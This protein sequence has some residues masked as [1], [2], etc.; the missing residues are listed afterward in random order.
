MPNNCISCV[1]GF[2][3]VDGVC[4]PKPTN[5][6]RNV[7]VIDGICQEYC[8]RECKTCNNTRGDCYECSHLYRRNKAGQC[9]IGSAALDFAARARFFVN[10]VRRGGFKFTFFVVDDLW[11]YSYHDKKY[12]GVVRQVLDVI[13]LV[14]EKQWELMGLTELK[15]SLEDSM[16]EG[17]PYNAYSNERHMEEARSNDVFVGNTVDFFVF[18]L[19][20]LLLFVFLCNR[21]FYLLFNYRVSFLLRPYSFWAVLLELAL[22]SN[23]EY[24]TFLGLRCLGIPFSFSCPSKWLLIL[25]VTM[26][27]LVV[28]T[29]FISYAL[30]Y[31]WYGKLARYFLVNMY[32]FPSSYAS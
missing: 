28:F 26:F 29:A 27:F 23:I 1:D 25:A 18:G 19:P 24:F 9:V 4:H 21:L 31:C 12:D 30:Y 3:L 2:V 32:R 22:Q 6:V 11:L 10:L 16:Q 20:A 13:Q 17:Q 15:Q 8:A 14:E 7:M 5:C